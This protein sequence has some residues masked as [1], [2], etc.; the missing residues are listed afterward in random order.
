[1]A[2]ALWITGGIAAAGI[3]GLSFAHPEKPKALSDV[4]GDNAEGRGVA[5]GFASR[6]GKDYSI[7]SLGGCKYRVHFTNAAGYPRTVVVEIAAVD[8]DGYHGNVTLDTDSMQRDLV[9]SKAIDAQRLTQ[10]Y[11][12]GK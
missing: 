1:M 4:C 7:S 5:Q 10:A 2:K 9:A 6:D 3:F 11:I 12:Q 8:R